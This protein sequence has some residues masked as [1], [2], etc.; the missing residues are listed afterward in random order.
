MQRI[1]RRALSHPKQQKRK[2]RDH[3]EHDLFLRFLHFTK[4]HRTHEPADQQ[5][6]PV[7]RNEFARLNLRKTRDVLLLRLLSGRL[8]VDVESA[9]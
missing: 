2:Q 9:A 4:L 5:T 6:A 7:K 3:Y 1:Q 8:I